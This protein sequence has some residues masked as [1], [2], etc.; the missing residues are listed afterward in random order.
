MQTMD[1]YDTCQ[2]VT[3]EVLSTG[4]DI[5]VRMGLVNWLADFLQ[6]NILIDV[7]PSFDGFEYEED[8]F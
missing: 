3:P 5:V 4:R 1:S 7:E 2:G 8:E 6:R